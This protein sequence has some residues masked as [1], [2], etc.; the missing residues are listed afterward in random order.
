MDR[1][2]GVA[3][4][5]RRRARNAAFWGA[6]G[7]ALLLVIAPV[8]SIFWEIVASA[9]PHWHWSVLT[10]DQSGNGGGL[11]NAV[12]GTL[13]IMVGVLVLAGTI[14]VGGGLYL[15][16]FSPGRRAQLLRGA[17]EVLAGVPSIVLGYVGYS[18]LVVE[19]HWGF[20]LAAALIVLTVLVIPYIVKT[21]EVAVRSVPTSYREGAEAL[22]MPDGYVLRRLVLQPALP[23]VVTGLIVAVAIA[24]GE[25]APLLYTAGWS[26]RAPTLALTHSPVGYLTYAVWTFYNEPYQ[27]AHVLAHEAALLLVVM[28]LVLIVAA[29]LVVTATQRHAATARPSARRRRRSTTDEPG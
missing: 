4:S 26:T 27:S 1:G 22:G 14:G 20:S 13:V 21:T 7:L 29:R 15:A 23:G 3:L 12:E 6:C 25:T 16:E 10:T 9:V 28:L 11:R 5:R 24:M 2:D 8:V 17:S 19:F 18:I